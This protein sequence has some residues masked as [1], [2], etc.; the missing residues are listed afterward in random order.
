MIGGGAAPAYAA[1]VTQNGGTSSAVSNSSAINCIEV[2][3]GAIVTGNITNTGTGVITANGGSPPTRTGITIYNASIGGAIVNVGTITASESGIVAANAAISGGISNTGTITAHT[4]G[5]YA[6]VSTF[7]GGIG[8]A[9]TISVGF[10]AIAVNNVSAFSG[11]ITNNAS[12]T[13][14]VGWTGIHVNNVSTFSGNI[15]N[16]GAI[17]AGTAYGILVN[18][19]STFAGGISNTGT[20]TARLADIYVENVGILNGG[21]SNA[22][23]IS[24]GAGVNVQLVSSF[25]GGIG[26]TGT[27]TAHTY[28]IYLNN[29]STFTGSI[30]NSSTI[31]SS[32]YAIVVS[33]ASTFAGDISN[34]GTI[35]ARTHS[36][37]VTAVSSFAGRISNAGVLSANQNGINVTNTGMFGSSI[38]VGGIT[39]SSTI[40]G[41]ND[42]I[43]LSTIS[44]FSGGISNVGTIS[45]GF[46]GVYVQDVS[47][48]AGGINSSGT[49][50]ATNNDGI[51]ISAVS[52]FSGGISSAGAISADK[53]GI[54]ISGVSTF[55]GGINNAGTISA[56]TIDGIYVNN[57][58]SFAG[59]VANTGT[60]S[61]GRTAIV[62]GNVSAFSG[63]ITNGNSGTLAAGWT[64]INVNNV[65]TFSGN[66]SNAGA[67]TGS[68]AYGILL[69]GISTF[70][71]A[72]A[73][74]GTIA[75]RLSGIYVE[76]VGSF[77]GG[78]SNAGMISGMASGINIVG[79]GTFVGGI[80][81]SGTIAA[82]GSGISLDSSTFSGGITNSGTISAGD[83][84][85]NA[86]RGITFAG[87]IAN[88][89]MISAQGSGI[90]VR[91]STF[92]GG[93]SNS[94]M[95]SAGSSGTRVSNVNSFGGGIANSGTIS[96]GHFGIDILGVGT[97][98]GGI[99]NSG[100][101]SSL[102]NG[103]FLISNSTFSGGIANSGTIAAQLT[104]MF[105]T[106]STFLGGITNSGMISAGNAGLNVNNVS[107]FAGGIVNSASGTITAATAISIGSGVTFAADST[108]VNSGTITGSAAA[109]D[110]HL[111]TSPVTIDQAGGT[112]NGAIKLSSNADVLNISGGAI[113]GNVV[114][115]GASNTINFNLGSSSFIYGSAYGFTGVNQVNVNSGTVV[116]NGSNSATSIAV[117]NGGVLAGVG[118]LSSANVDIGGT[119]APGTPGVAGTIMNI[120]GNL[121]FQSGAIYLVTIAGASVSRVDVTG[122]V[123][124]NGTLDVVVQPGNFKGNTHY[125]ILD[126]TSISGRFSSVNIL[127]LPSSYSAVVTYDTTDVYLDLRAS[128]GA[129]DRLN[130]NQQNAA[131]AINGYFNA[132]GPL[133]AGFS[134]LFTIP[135]P[136][137]ALSQLSGEP[138]TDASK[139]AGQFMNDFLVLM[140]DPTRSGGGGS[141]GDG[142]AGFAPEQ[143]SSLPRDVA[144]A[145]A[146][147]LRTP[148]PRDQMPSSFDQSWSAWGSAFGGTSVTDGN[149]ALGSNNVTAHDHGLAAGID[150]RATPNVTYGFGLTGGGTNW[151]LAQAL[152]GGRSDAF[153]AGIYSKTHWGP[154]YLSGALAFANHWFTTDRVALGDPLHAKFTGQSYGG[155]LETGY[156]YS[157]PI[158]DTQNTGAIVGVTPYAAFQAQDLRT[159][160]YSET[161]LTGGGFGLS[162]NAMSATDIRSEFGARFDNLQVVNGMPLGLRSRLAW[163]HDW[164]RDPSLG[165]VFQALSGANFTVNGAATP[166]NSA[167]TT[168]AAE[169][170]INADW[171]AMAR[172]EGVFGMGSQTYGGAG[173]LKY[174]W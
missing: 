93:I 171:T 61:V 25:A 115:Q 156:R 90:V 35:S 2:F 44:A 160:G 97:F 127:N 129:G 3:N 4:H 79:L 51:A 117:N 53:Y 142:A 114:G 15:S 96:A 5:V 47:T 151:N 113:A 65:S 124:L 169:L 31:S 30:S 70:A 119:L 170:H 158:T 92:S 116:L 10:T 154:L 22:G 20:I 123:S 132:G 21:I 68:T 64:G 103:I 172:F 101:I 48:F 134:A 69:N 17:S 91:S 33:G 58:S 104:G 107:V 159:P 86:Y 60:I 106:G 153:G 173:T 110:V 140:L 136:G 41:G 39:N 94:G 77:A 120:N 36:I 87:G 34:T 27:I 54:V 76:H 1:C 118:T 81:N 9:G 138:A 95:I 105:V 55:A 73:N 82:N 149:A 57:V 50:S 167:L 45:A 174:S 165:A 6:N 99:S 125:D 102:R 109:I 126:P 19:I 146:K 11:G 121:A 145:Y 152:G 59:G 84:G 26:N 16:A 7:A 155:R 13:L 161:D 163:A 112:I 150:Y 100:T 162:Y 23:T 148:R 157:V 63:G 168:A 12:G 143:D 78:I 66:I 56:R 43:F 29:V 139:G 130:V 135:N 14:A 74:T 122:A 42:A 83:T 80:S 8:N 32:R 137:N 166:K 38:A 46:T 62:V 98:A 111:A 88:S 85:I 89:G 37:Y 28:G 75:A 71:G 52:V 133:P 67:I 72:V 24:A 147:A 144:F 164:A 49:I 131:N 141:N 128:L 108:I 18:G 40:S